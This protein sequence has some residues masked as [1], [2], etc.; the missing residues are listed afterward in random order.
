MSHLPPNRIRTRALTLVCSSVLILHF[1][2]TCVFLMPLSILGVHFGSTV[3]RYM[4]P[5][6]QQRWSLFAP[7][8]PLRNVF[9]HF[10]CEQENGEMS[11]WLDRASVLKQEH[12]LYRFTP[13]SYLFR[14]DRA[15]VMTALGAKDE[16]FEKV[17]EKVEESGDERLLSAMQAASEAR[18]KTQLVQQRFV[19]RLVA[20]HCRSAVGP[21]VRGVRPRIVFQDIP[22]YSHRYD[23]PAEEPSSVVEFPWVA[24]SAIPSLGAQEELQR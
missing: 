24:V 1:V 19:Y 5:L 7:D 2:A 11:P 23:D 8:P 14:V 6:F 20:E 4:V 9:L 3:N 22:K 10:Q 15:A 21:H 12:A 17:L 16:V 18:S 13:E